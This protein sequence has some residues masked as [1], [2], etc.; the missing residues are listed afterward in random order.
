VGGEA[1]LRFVWLSQPKNSQGYDDDQHPP[2]EG[3]SRICTEQVHSSNP[4]AGLRLNVVNLKK[5][6]TKDFWPRITPI[7]RM[8]AL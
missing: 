7:T 6:Q 3:D 1:A 4:V 5:A 2:H 8:G